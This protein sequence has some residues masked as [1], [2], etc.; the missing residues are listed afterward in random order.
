MKLRHIVVAG[1]AF[2]SLSAF[3]W[4]QGAKNQS[5]AP[6]NNQ[7][8]SQMSQAQSPDIVREAQQQL[9]SQGYDPGPADGKF[10]PKTQKEIK[11]FQ[12]DR[13]LQ[14]SGRLDQQ[15]LAALGVS[16]SASAGSSSTSGS[17]SSNQ[18]SSSSSSMSQ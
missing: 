7:R 9:A 10:G 11:K 1:A 17:G 18:N 12:E 16:Q 8:S 13:Q 3:G 2:A 14:S 15:T 5:Q 6:S 4:D